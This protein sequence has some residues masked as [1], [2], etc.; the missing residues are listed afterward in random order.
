[1]HSFFHF[2]QAERRGIFFF[3]LLISAA[4][5]WP[6]VYGHY[7]HKDQ[8]F[9][10]DLQ[11]LDTLT[12]KQKP[13]FKK[14]QK[15]R[16]EVIA[17]TDTLFHFDPNQVNLEQLILL[18]LPAKVAHTLL[19]FREKGGRFYQKTDLLKVYG[20]EENWY[21]EVQDYIQLPKTSQRSNFSKKPPA[22]NYSN[23]SDQAI[24]VEVNQ[25]AAEDWARLK[26]IGPVLSNRIVKFREKLGG[27]YSID[28]IGQTYG[29]ADSVFQKIKDQLVLEIRLQPFRINELSKQEL[30]SHPY[31]GWKEA[32]IISSYRAMHGP[33]KD[34]AALDKV[35]A[36]DQEKI[37]L[38]VP[39]ID[40][41]FPCEKE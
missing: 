39:Y 26:G 37:Q 19:N 25:A 11:K 29:L 2:K 17:P 32:Q 40:F 38:L 33:F 5:I 9:A 15:Y 36:L 27:F 13:V 31:L 24:S 7:Q 22:S 16:A 10:I 35:H 21:H 28:Q 6:K 30:A 3:L 23:R 12:I 8:S 34:R 20:L 41:C 14:P 4:L 18:G 1:M